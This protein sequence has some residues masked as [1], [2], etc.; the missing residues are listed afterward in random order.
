MAVCLT[1]AKKNILLVQIGKEKSMGRCHIL[2]PNDPIGQTKYFKYLLVHY[3]QI[4]GMR[5][6]SRC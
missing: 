6:D 1:G 2:P 5:V 4:N 3:V